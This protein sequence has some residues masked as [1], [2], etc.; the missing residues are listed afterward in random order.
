MTPRD[1]LGYKDLVNFIDHRSNYCQV[2]HAKNKGAAAMHYKHFLKLLNDVLI[3]KFMSCARTAEAS[4][5]LWTYFAKSLV[6]YAK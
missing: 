1:R 2:F 3:A 5:N 6:Y 4:T